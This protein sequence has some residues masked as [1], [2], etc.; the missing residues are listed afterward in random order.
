MGLA[1]KLAA[2]SGTGGYAGQAP[3]A[4]YPGQQAPPQG[5]T[6]SYPGQ[7]QYAPYPGSGA[8]AGQRPPQ[9]PPYPGAQGGQGY[10]APPPGQYGAPPPQ[11]GQAAAG[12]GAGPRPPQ[13]ASPEAYKQLLQG[14]VREKGLQ[15]FRWP[16]PTFLDDLSRAATTR[17]PDFCRKWNVPAEIGNDVVK[18][19][20]QEQASKLEAT[21]SAQSNPAYRAYSTSS[22]LLTTPGPC[23]SRR[24]AS[25]STT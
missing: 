23:A 17:C 14:V 11:Y 25:A 1:S 8:Q 7:Q 16:A 4:Q 3:P 24:V 18:L 15:N 6:G 12:P 13:G 19:V 9:Q 10:G 5:G 20:C 2:S 22:S 21:L